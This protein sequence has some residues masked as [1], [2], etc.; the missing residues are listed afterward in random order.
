MKLPK[1]TSLILQ[2]VIVYIA[3]HLFLDLP[4]PY[5]Y[6]LMLFAFWGVL[7]SETTIENESDHKELRE[8]AN[9]MARKT[10]DTLYYN[11]GEGTYYRKASKTILMK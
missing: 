5:D 2:V 10:H 11:I 9:K 3:A 7:F 6:F 1:K 4:F 8:E